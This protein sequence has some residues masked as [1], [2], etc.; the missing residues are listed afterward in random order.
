MTERTTQ[1]KTRVGRVVSA[2][3]DKTV[4][5]AVE[6]RV[7]HRLY[8]K[9]VRRVKKFK[10]H[11]EANEYRVGDVVRLIETRP[12]SRTKRWRVAQLLHRDETPEVD[13][14]V[15]AESPESG[16]AAEQESA[17]V[18]ETVDEAAE[19][20]SEAEG[21]AEESPAE[22]SVES[23][24]PEPVDEAAGGPPEAEGE[25]AA[26][27]EEPVAEAAEDSSDAETDQAGE[28]GEAGGG[29]ARP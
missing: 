29:E 9:S 7:H 21:D 23:S 20:S 12:L 11:D 28:A 6:R 1:R 18:E 16:P 27:V 13:F 3:M 2:A 15:E 17:S 14:A 5:V 24:E 19:G 4:V 10:A 8:H 22:A 25:G 26:A